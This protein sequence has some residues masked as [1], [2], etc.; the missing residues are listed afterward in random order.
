M[1]P[2]LICKLLILSD[3]VRNFLTSDNLVFFSTE[4]IT[5]K[6]KDYDIQKDETLGEYF[7][8]VK[9]LISTVTDLD[10]NSDPNLDVGSH[11]RVGIHKVVYLDG[12]ESH[13]TL[14]FFVEFVPD[15]LLA[16]T[17]EVPGTYFK[18][19]KGNDVKLYMNA[20]DDGSAPVIRYGADNKIWNPPRLWHDIYNAICAAKHFVYAVG[21]S[22]DVDQYL[23]RGAELDLMKDSKYSPRFGELLKQKADEGVVV[24]LMQ[25]YVRLLFLVV[26][27]L[28]ITLII[29]LVQ[30]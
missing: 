13:G 5:F 26:K 19:H 7:L 27:K 24:N 10:A 15:E 16:T 30:G 3:F 17:L 11:R 21:W 4:G 6:V 2:W 18:A 9:E 1:F 14:E 25:W 8:A 23:L 12:K 29:Y 22:F 28:N 20:D